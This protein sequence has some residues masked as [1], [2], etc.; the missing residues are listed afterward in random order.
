[1]IE[2]K[3]VTKR[4]D[5]L[6]ALKSV[7]ATVEEG[8]VFGLIGTNGSG[9]STLLRSICGIYRPE[10]GEV[11][12]DGES[13][14]EN[15]TAKSKIFYISDDQFFFANGTPMDMVRFYQTVY[16]G[17]DVERFGK[18]METLKLDVKRKINTFSKGMKKQLSVMLGVSAGTKYLLC[19]ET[20]DGL[21]PVIRQAIKS[22]FIKEMAD[23]GMTPIIASHNLRELEDIC[24][25]VGLLHEGGILFSKDLDSMKLGIFKLQCVLQTP[26]H[27]D[28]IAEQFPI[29]N[30]IQ[31]GTLTTLTLRGK[32]S[33]ISKLQ[34]ELQ[35]IFWELLPL[36]LEE[37]FISEMEVKGYDFS[38][39]YE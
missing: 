38:K 12:I 31:T 1:M 11:V 10:E 20:F 13:V 23:R 14:Y 33:E 25:H 35:P 8:Q 27:L 2:I 7:S 34:M 26:E 17:F 22:L 21:D 15:P 24:D 16:P 18:L 3:G 36:T 9:K 19:D 28:R 4:F 5:E 37:I 32:S 39:I 6:V 30:K 29:L